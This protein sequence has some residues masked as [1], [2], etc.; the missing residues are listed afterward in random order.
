M[1]INIT[2]IL[3]LLSLKIKEIR[4]QYFFIFEFFIVGYYALF[5]I[6][7]ITFLDYD[8]VTRIILSTVVSLLL[9][10]IHTS[11][12]SVYISRSKCLCLFSIDAGLED[13][14]NK[15]TIPEKLKKAFKNTNFFLPE[16][17]IVKKE[18]SEW[19][20]TVK[21]EKEIYSIKKADGKLNIY[22]V[23]KETYTI[24]VFMNLVLFTVIKYLLYVGILKIDIM[25]VLIIIL[26]LII[27]YQ[28]FVGYVQGYSRRI[29][30]H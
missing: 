18:D 3:S 9:F 12:L 1:D 2:G 27:V 8:I 25:L 5:C 19:M 14:L 10:T 7:G 17:A 29:L 23:I 4:E 13:G 28:C 30:S 15:G 24:P 16:E 6:C 20:I 11:L 21:E 26:V 22:K